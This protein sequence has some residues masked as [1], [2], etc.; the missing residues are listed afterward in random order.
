[1][2]GMEGVYVC[3][4]DYEDE[5]VCEV[6]LGLCCALWLSGSK[7]RVLRERK[8]SSNFMFRGTTQHCR[9]PLQC[10]SNVPC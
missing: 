2:K 1:M 3:R 6:A 4:S 9:N 5:R 8:K 10:L 7:V